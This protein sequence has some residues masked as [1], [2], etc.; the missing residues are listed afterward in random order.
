MGII[1]EVNK[2]RVKGHVEAAVWS[3]KNAEALA[4]MLGPVT[5]FVARNDDLVVTKDGV[6]ITVSVGQWLIKL[7]DGEFATCSGAEFVDMYEVAVDG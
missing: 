2:Y 4:Q 1:T 5:H 7:S 3:G 6:S